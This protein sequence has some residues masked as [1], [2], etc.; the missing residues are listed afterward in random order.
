MLCTIFLHEVFP[1]IYQVIISN[2][3]VFR[4]HSKLVWSSYPKTTL[5][6]SNLFALRVQQGRR[7]GCSGGRGAPRESFK[8]ILPCGLFM[9]CKVLF[10][11][12][13]KIPFETSIKL[14]CPRLF[15]LA[16]LFLPCK[17]EGRKITRKDSQGLEN[18]S[19]STGKR[20]KNDTKST[21]REGAG[22]GGRRVEGTVL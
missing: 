6:P 20:P 10:R 1:K 17:V 22:G 16:R 14:T 8:V 15:S 5:T 21:P 12:P 11:D 9:L 7:A 2:D 13:Q 18:D 3:M 19:K 4:L